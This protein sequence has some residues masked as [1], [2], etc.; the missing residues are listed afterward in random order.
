MVYLYEFLRECRAVAQ[1][2]FSLT[3]NWWSLI[4]DA[5]D[6]NGHFDKLASFST[7]LSLCVYLLSCTCANSGFWLWLGRVSAEVGD[8]PGKGFST[9]KNREFCIALPLGFFVCELFQLGCQS[10]LYVLICVTESILIHSVRTT[11]IRELLIPLTSLNRGKEK[12]I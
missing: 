9:L 2:V 4:K 11:R 12:D 3:F 1:M 6:S 7:V 5:V 10:S 8:A